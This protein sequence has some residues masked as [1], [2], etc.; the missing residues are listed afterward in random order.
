MKNS[1]LSCIE[2]NPP[3]PPIGSVIWLHGLGADGN[4]FVPIVSAL[5]LPD[6]LPLRFIF[7]TAPLQPVTLNNGYIMRAWYDIVGLSMKERTDHDGINQ[8]INLIK[9]LIEKE[10]Q[11]GISPNKIILAGFS[12]GAVMAL[13][14]GLSYPHALG[15]ILAL[16]GYLPDPEYFLK[17][18]SPANHSTPIFIA[19]GTEDDVVAHAY[20]VMAHDFL[21]DQGCAV[22]W[23]SYSMAH[24]VCEEEVGDIARWLVEVLK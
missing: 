10:I 24:S 8:S 20:G 21:K 6:E 11:A 17:L 15:G 4:D 16:S 1:S 14:T 5:N 3:K 23:H 19:H 18:A 13:A 9:K 2:L 22:E 12:Q 7:P